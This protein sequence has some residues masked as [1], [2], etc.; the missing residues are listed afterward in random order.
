MKSPARN[1]PSASA[2]KSLVSEYIKSEVKLGQLVGPIPE[3]LTPL[4]KVSPIGLIPKPHQVNK[5]RMI[6]DLSHPRNH[7]VNAG[8]SEELASITYAHVDEA[9]ECIQA[10]GAGA[11]LTKMDLDSAYRQIPVHPEDHKLLGISWEGHTYVDRVLTFGLR[12]APKIFSAVADMMA[13]ALHI[14]GIEHLIHYLDDFLFLEAPHTSRGTRMPALALETFAYLGVPVSAHKTEGPA[15][16]VTFLGI[17]IDTIQGQLRLPQEK[18]CRLQERIRDWARKKSCT[19]RE[20]ECFL[21][22]LCHAATVV[23]PGRTFL[24]E[25]FSLLHHVRLPHHFI[26]LTAGAHADIRW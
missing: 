1:H 21:G 10:L 22:H 23:R 8:I 3:S 5:W 25:L 24:R 16:L 14:A 7:S 4:V 12:S 26:R 6:V 19:R 2:N 13:W 9:V 18:L 15:C 11:V 20:L 17:L